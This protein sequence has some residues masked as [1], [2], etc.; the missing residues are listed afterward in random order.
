MIPKVQ[1]ADDKEQNLDTGRTRQTGPVVLFVGL[2]L[3]DEKVLHPTEGGQLVRVLDPTLVRYQHALL[4]PAESYDHTWTLLRVVELLDSGHLTLDVLKAEAGRVGRE[5]ERMIGWEKTVLGPRYTKP[6][7]QA[8]KNQAH[9]K[10][11]NN[12]A[13]MDCLVILYRT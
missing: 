2:S 5:E 8:E 3:G 7:L 9:Y 12:I 11:K 4:L 13:M 10:Y 6:G 1:S